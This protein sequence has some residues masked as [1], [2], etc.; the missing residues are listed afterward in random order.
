MARYRYLIVG[1]GM[2]ADAALHGIRKRDAKGSIGLVAAESHPPYNR[3][4]L[5][6]G[7]WKGEAEESVWRKSR[8]TGVELHLGRRAVSLDPRAQR[9]TDNAGTVYEYEMLLLATG[10]TPRRLAGAP[11]GLIY[12]RTL[13][14]YRRSRPLADREARVVV[15]GG[16]VCSPAGAPA[17]PRPPRA[18]ARARGPRV[19]RRPVPLPGRLLP[20]GGRHDA[21]GRVGGAGG[22]RNRRLPDPHQ[23]LR[24]GRGRRGRGRSRHR[25]RPGPRPS[26]R[27]DRPG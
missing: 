6:K 16:G 18:P 26:G 9:I 15:I 2:T 10:G 25:A 14:D 8:E 17:P 4:P 5:S 20:P 21:H 19:S 24:R 3:P 12:F 1:G 27:A 22:S 23:G 13:D 11:D 7:L